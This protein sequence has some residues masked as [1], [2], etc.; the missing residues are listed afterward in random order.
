M[1]DVVIYVDGVSKRYDLGE[2]AD[3]RSI[4]SGLFK[5]SKRAPAVVDPAVT[6]AADAPLQVTVDALPDAGGTALLELPANETTPDDYDRA[7]V[8]WALK[9]V[10]FEVPHGEIMGVI[11]RNGAGKSTLL[12]IMSKI[13]EPTEGRIRISGR[14]GSL[15]EIG[16]GFHPELTG[17]ENI[18]LNGAIIGMSRREINARFNEIVE[19]SE[20]GRFIDTPVKRYSSGM[21]TRLAFAVSAHLDPEIL[22]IDEVLS[23]G[24]AA[25]Q[26]KCMRKMTA[27]MKSGKTVMFVSHSM[28]TVAELCTHA[29]LLQEGQVLATGKTDEVIARYTKVLSD[30]AEVV[31]FAGGKDEARPAQILSVQLLNA[32]GE[33]QSTFDINDEFR[34][35]VTFEIL[36]ESDGVQLALLLSRNMAE[37]MNTFDTDSGPDRLPDRPPGRYESTLSMPAKFLKA[38]GYSLQL[39]IGSPTQLFQLIENA[40]Q[41]KI[42]E[43]SEIGQHRGYR[44]ERLGHIIC[45]GT[46]TTEQ[47]L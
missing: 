5:K 26:K 14:V 33:A 10:T 36:R 44:S 6:Q 37:V 8:L 24:D 3:Y 43:L 27:L 20:I 30:G 22:I 1:K 7:K 23:V 40:A 32:R 19:F 34:I 21:F 15:L 42:V 31:S 13:T 35:R 25:F 46:W 9:D 18:Y 41:F 39:A 47:V 4:G 17:R 12:K 11:G 29:V 2:M 28:G 45:P 38:G 16:T